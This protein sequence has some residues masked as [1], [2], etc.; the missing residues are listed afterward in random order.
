MR[1]QLHNWIADNGL[2][3]EACFS[4]PARYRQTELAAQAGAIAERC[5]GITPAEV[6]PTL[7]RGL[8]YTFA[9]AAGGQ[10]LFLKIANPEADDGYIAVEARALQ[11]ARDH[12]VLAPKVLSVNAARSEFPLSFLLMERVPGSNLADLQREGRLDTAVVFRKIGSNLARLHSIT[13]DGFGFLQRQDSKDTLAGLNHS[14][15]EY[16]Y[17]RLPEQLHYLQQNDWVDSETLG[18]V[19]RAVHQNEGRLHLTRGSLIN[20]DFGLWNCIGTSSQLN[21]IVDWDSVIS[22]DPLTD[23]AAAFCSYDQQALNQIRAG[24]LEESRLPDAFAVRLGLHVIRD[25]VPRTIVRSLWGEVNLTSSPEI[26][27]AF[28]ADL[29]TICAE[30]LQYGLELL[31]E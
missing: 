5:T 15:Q 26:R 24:Y 3:A 27:R 10:N 17:N 1:T 4:N 30:K 28:N 29:K 14:Y 6:T 18:R 7:H 2:P 31:K 9:I 22:G 8:H 11:I 12:G 23:F 13:L 25:I 20:Q 19:L 21:G 16:Y